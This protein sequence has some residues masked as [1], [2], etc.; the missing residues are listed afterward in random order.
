MWNVQVFP[1]TP[2][3]DFA[4]LL[5]RASSLRWNKV[6]VVSANVVGTYPCLGFSSMLFY[7]AKY[8]ED[9]YSHERNDS[10]LDDSECHGREREQWPID[11]RILEVK[12]DRPM[13]DQGSRHSVKIEEMSLAGPLLSNI[14]ATAPHDWNT[15]CENPI[16]R[17]LRLLT[18]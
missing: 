3:H 8:L 2:S 4:S 9:L 17:D 10:I 18:F 13:T 5:E 6:S 14:P 1:V 16:S 7:I 12:S 11:R 15:T